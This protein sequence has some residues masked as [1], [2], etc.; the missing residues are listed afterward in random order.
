MLHVKD[1][2]IQEI[3]ACEIWNGGNSACGIWYPRNTVQ[4]IWNPA[5]DWS[6]ESSVQ[7]PESRVWNPESKT[8]LH[9]AR[10]RRQFEA[11]NIVT[12]QLLL[13][14][15]KTTTTKRKKQQH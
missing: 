10:E 13:T 8:V 7:N 9:G 15:G 5:N 6:P 14:L 1:S 3:F 11:G 2:E 12:I 4:G